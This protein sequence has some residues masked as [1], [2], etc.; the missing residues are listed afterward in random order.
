MSE[1]CRM[2]ISSW[3]RRV[4]GTCI[5]DARSRQ[6]LGYGII[7]LSGLASWARRT[8][9][10]AEDRGGGMAGSSAATVLKIPVR[11]AILTIE[12]GNPEVKVAIDREKGEATINGAGL[13]E[14]R[15]LL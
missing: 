13:Q 15:L 2:S 8:S 11:E 3:I 5:M 9:A 12:V 1:F 6:R 10:I 14:I 4:A 7:L